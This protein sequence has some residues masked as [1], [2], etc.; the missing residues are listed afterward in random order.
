MV[1]GSSLPT[2]SH[3]GDHV[4]NMQTAT[5]RSGVWAL[6]RREGTC[7]QI[8]TPKFCRRL[9]SLGGGQMRPNMQQ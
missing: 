2:V 6:G 5:M 9:R 8:H 1:A 4:Y 3:T 7:K